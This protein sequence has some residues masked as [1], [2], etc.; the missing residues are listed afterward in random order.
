MH[1]V[2]LVWLLLSGALSAPAA[3]SAK[4]E[5]NAPG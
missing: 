3:A 1:L 4:P 2:L 5:A